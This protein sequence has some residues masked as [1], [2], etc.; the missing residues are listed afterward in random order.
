MQ[1]ENLGSDYDVCFPCSA[2]KT[3]N[4]EHI[5]VNQSDNY[6]TIINHLVNQDI[7]IEILM[8][9]VSKIKDR[10]L[11]IKRIKKNLKKEILKFKTKFIG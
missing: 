1:I 8:K 4:I 11:F 9:D 3:G 5:E 2:A 7:K 10:G 6:Q